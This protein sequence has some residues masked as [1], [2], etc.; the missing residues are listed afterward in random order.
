MA[1]E[2]AR[3]VIM[4]LLYRDQYYQPNL[5]DVFFD[6]VPLLLLGSVFLLMS[7]RDFYRARSTKEVVSLTI[8]GE[9]SRERH[10]AKPLN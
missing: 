1:G 8:E 6:W 9:C 4:G 7:I 5:F 3:M 2:G 10:K